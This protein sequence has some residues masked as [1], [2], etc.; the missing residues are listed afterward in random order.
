MNTVKITFDVILSFLMDI[1]RE[2]QGT[3]IF[4]FI[5]LR[6]T[7]SFGV[8]F[9]E[10]CGFKCS[11]DSGTT[12]W[13]LGKFGKRPV[14]EPIARWPMQTWAFSTAQYRMRETWFYIHTVSLCISCFY[15]KPFLYS[16]TLYPSRRIMHPRRFYTKD[17]LSVW[18][19]LDK[20]L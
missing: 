9:S 1:Y 12:L 10:I 5:L 18:T 8:L 16:G 4:E 20:H 7:N 14:D 19:N 13:N 6:Q 15:Y 17:A 3:R 2:G 11:S